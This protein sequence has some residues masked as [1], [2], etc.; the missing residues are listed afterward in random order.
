MATTCNGSISSTPSVFGLITIT[1]PG[2]TAAKSG[3]ATGT[4]VPSLKRNTNGLVFRFNR[5]RIK[6][7]FIVHENSRCAGQVQLC[8][9][10]FLR[11]GVVPVSYTHLRAHET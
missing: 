2:E 6:F 11:E 8:K 9:R 4:R 5:S 3:C 7:E 1:F 10:C